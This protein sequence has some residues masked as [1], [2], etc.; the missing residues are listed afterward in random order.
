MKKG[1]VL[2]FALSLALTSSLFAKGK[3][4]PCAS[5]AKSLGQIVAAQSVDKLSKHIADPVR[6]GMAPDEPAE[7]TK[8][9]FIAR[10]GAKEDWISA[11][12]FKTLP[13]SI[14]AKMLKPSSNPSSVVPLQAGSCVFEDEYEAYTIFIKP[15]TKDWMIYG[16]ITY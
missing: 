3:T 9:D 1:I 8:K 2:Y 4:L 13:K 12:F 16:V 11:L 15:S 7:V 5:V 10:L 14:K 6:V